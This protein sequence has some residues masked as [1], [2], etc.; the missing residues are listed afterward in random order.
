MGKD[1]QRMG[2]SATTKVNRNDF[3]VSALPAV[4]GDEITITLDIEMVRPMPK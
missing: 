4:I 2:A 3:G 1:R